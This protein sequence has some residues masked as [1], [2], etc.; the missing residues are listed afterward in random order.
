MNKKLNPYSAKD[1]E[2]RVRFD[3]DEAEF[4]AQVVEIPGII[5][6]AVTEAEAVRKVRECLAET[7]EW[8]NREGDILAAPGEMPPPVPALKPRA[9]RLSAA[10]A[11]S[12]LGRLGGLAKSPRKTT[13]VR[14]NGM[15]GAHYG[16]LGGRPKKKALATA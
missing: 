4:T 10:Q 13:A 5:L 7:I 14:R 9:Q 11:A 3:I 2:L 8:Y 16:K 15:L 1:Y 6:G 12:A